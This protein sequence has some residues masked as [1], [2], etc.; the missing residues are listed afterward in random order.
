MDYLR[1]LLVPFSPTSLLLVGTFSVLMTILGIGGLYGM[2]GSLFLQIW[3]L[4]YGYV[5]IEHIADGASEP[6]VMSVD[7]LSPFESRPWLQLGIIGLGVWLCYLLG[8]KAGIVLGITLLL[9][10]PASIAALGMGE[11]AYQAVNPLML[12][13]V[14]RGLGPYYLAILVSIPIYLGLLALLQRLGAWALFSHAARLLCEISFFS[15]IGG[16]L[17]LRRAQIGYEPSRSPER[18]A[19][20]EEYE[21]LKVRARMLDEVFQLVR[22]GKHVDA[23]RPL[24][25]WLGDLDETLIV[26]DSL[27]VAEQAARWDYTAGLNTIASTLIRHL[28]RAGRADAA[29]SVFELLRT[30]APGL[31]LDSAPDLRTLID[32]AESVGRAEL[33][34]SMRLETPVFQPRR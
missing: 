2:I 14:V 29:L 5:L 30:R 11:P 31:T 7:T 1:V 19:A 27:Y 8:G 17:Y 10:L 28:L 6:P 4:K 33:A 23:T 9:L 25:R 13:R 18:A 12:L 21:R 20:R 16:C 15:L 22:I 24:A 32:Y 3:V 26:R 34:Q